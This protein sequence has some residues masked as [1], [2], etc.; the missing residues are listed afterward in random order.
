M[1]QE[2]G[3]STTPIALSPVDRTKATNIYDHWGQ[4]LSFLERSNDISPFNSKFDAYLRGAT[5]P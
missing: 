4:S 2:F 1:G 5:T 3:G